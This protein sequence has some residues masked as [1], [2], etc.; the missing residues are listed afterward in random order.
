MDNTDNVFHGFMKLPK[1]LLVNEEF[2]GVSFDAKMLFTMILDRTELSCKNRERFADDGGEVFVYFTIDEICKRFGCGHNKAC[3]LLK[4][5][6]DYNLI[7][8]KPKKCGKPNRLVIGPRFRHFLDGEYY[9]PRN[10]KINNPETGKSIVPKEDGIN[11]YNNNTDISKTESSIIY[12]ETV[13]EI[14]EQIEYDLINADP[15]IVQEIIMIVADVVTYPGKTIRIGGVDYP[16]SLVEKRYRLLR[17]EHV[18]SVV[19]R[20][21]RT[22]KEVHNVRNYIMTLLFNAPATYAVGEAAEIACALNNRI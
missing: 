4:Q 13:E 20:L 15:E 18:E 16:K 9:K 19:E 1:E 5:L 11:T 3:G 21:E 14:K 7:I 8:K 2:S 17:A 10:G 6:V 22:D 12:D